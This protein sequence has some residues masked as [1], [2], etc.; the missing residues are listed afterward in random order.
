[1]RI[2]LRSKFILAL[3]VNGLVSTLL[4]VWIAHARL[5]RKFD[6]HVMG[7]A[8]QAFCQDVEAYFHTY[9]SWEEAQRHED[10]PAFSARRRQRAGL[11]SLDGLSPA[12]DPEAVMPPLEPLAGPKAVIHGELPGHPPFL[13]YLFD[14]QWRA[15]LPLP[16]YHDGQ[17]IRGGQRQA[18][19][20]IIADG[21]LLAYYSPMGHA[22]YSDRDLGYLA[23][24][25]EA[26]FY[27]AGAAILLTLIL[28]VKLGDHL[29]A[30]LRPL[31]AAIQAMEQG[32]LKQHVAVR[33]GDEVGL[34]AQAFNRMS[35]ELARSA[36]DL[37]HAHEQVRLQAAQ[38][39]ELSV[40]DGLTGLHNR[41]YFEEQ[42]QILFNLA[43]RYQRPF[44][45]MLGDVDFFKGIN[46]G[47]SHAVGDEV[48]RRLG[49][50]LRS[51]VR[52]VDIA[53]RYGGEEFIVAF[54]ET[55]LESAVLA[56]EK[57]RQG[58]EQ[59][60]WRELGSGLQVTMSM[61]LCGNDQMASLE[62]MVKTADAR[63][64]RAKAAGRNRICWDGEPV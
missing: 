23:A 44:T 18:F 60:P 47:F 19:Q 14:P 50:I 31:T 17:P 5:V 56:C 24:I 43:V 51:Q 52:E 41:R 32:D 25:R 16:P 8:S 53:V 64:Y 34:V 46:D 49:E 55:P 40:R 1:M 21:R 59:H 30:A 38:L 6:D 61:G 36:E 39:R 37:R 33:S 2:S 28:G 58:I 54:P 7:E 22:H 48:L 13:F 26:M 57:L 12:A 10:F 42:G 11:P 20:P 4:V 35:D 29:V 15:L 9:G 45:V 62:A 63:L 27:G 3:L